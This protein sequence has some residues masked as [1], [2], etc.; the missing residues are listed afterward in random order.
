MPDGAPFAV[1]QVLKLN[2]LKFFRKHAN[3]RI[4]GARR[5]QPWRRRRERRRG[6]ADGGPTEGAQSWQSRRRGYG[7][8][9]GRR[10]GL[11]SQDMKQQ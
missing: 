1:Q 2:M 7:G 6:A 5:H 3:S 9:C 4:G 8:V 11:A 10:R